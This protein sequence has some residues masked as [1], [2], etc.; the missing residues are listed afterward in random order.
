M[1]NG[2]LRFD[3]NYGRYVGR[4]AETVQ[5]ALAEREDRLSPLFHLAADEVEGG[6]TVLVWQVPALEP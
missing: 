3:A 1:G 2:R 5:E 6:G 4:L